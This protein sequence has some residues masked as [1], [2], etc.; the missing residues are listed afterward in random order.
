MLDA[1]QPPDVG[2]IQRSK[3]NHARLLH[4]FGFPL[5]FMARPSS[6]ITHFYRPMCSYRTAMDAYLNP[7]TQLEI[8][9]TV[10]SVSHLLPRPFTRGFRLWR[11]DQIHCSSSFSPSLCVFVV[12]SIQ[13][14]EGCCRSKLPIRFPRAARDHRVQLPRWKPK[15]ASLG[16]RW[17]CP[18]SWIF[19]RCLRPKWDFLKFNSS[20][21]TFGLLVCLFA[22]SVLIILKKKEDFV[23]IFGCSS[24]C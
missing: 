20:N 10:I 8:I 4:T 19:L 17:F 23:L 16:S 6:T 2:R 5:Q 11:A 3:A 12:C 13:G 22:C 14:G 15:T 18:Q 7:E 21:G 9:I 1:Q 24:F